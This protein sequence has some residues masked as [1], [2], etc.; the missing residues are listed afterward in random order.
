MDLDGTVFWYLGGALVVAALAVSY[1]GIR[2]KGSFPASNRAFAAIA[3]PFAVLVVATG[4]YAWA[5]AEEEQEHRDEE[6]AHEEALAE[7]GGAEGEQE[8]APGGSPSG[9]P[10]EPTPGPPGGTENEKPPGPPGEALDVTS[11][12]DG[13]LAFEPDGLQAPAGTIT[14][15]YDNPSPVI[16]NINVEDAEGQTLKESEDVTDG[17]VEIDFEAVPGEYLYYCSIAGHREGGMEGTL[18]VE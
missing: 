11:P 6:L 9:E 1:V 15:V 2:G 3:I 13:S 12:E 7:P 4:A 18:T 5:N 14:L 17:T 16:H 10:A 8:P